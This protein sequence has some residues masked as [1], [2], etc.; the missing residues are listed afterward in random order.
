MRR[1][2]TWISIVLLLL[3]PVSA[4]AQEDPALL[5]RLTTLDGQPIANALVL[6]RDRSGQQ[7]IAQTTTDAQGEAAFERIPLDTVRV[8]VQGTTLGGATLVQKG[9]SAEGVLV[10]VDV[11]GYEVDLL[12][13]ADG[14][15]QLNPDTSIA[16]EGGAP[17]GAQIPTAVIAPT[18][19][20]PTAAPV[21]PVADAPPDAPLVDAPATD[22]DAA[23]G[24][25]GYL[26]GGGVMV[27]VLAG[28]MF[29]LRSSREVI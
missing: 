25:G 9:S 28:L 18:I 29:M 20:A 1:S 7:T 13:A 11:G 10:F 24:L 5:V 6:V 14:M 27:L 26:I 4:W 12:V 19:T 21:A 3:A 15:V 23:G 22:A 17:S 2:I 16:L 8:K